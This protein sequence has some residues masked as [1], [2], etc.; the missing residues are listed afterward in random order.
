[1]P[2]ETD[3]AAIKTA[4]VTPAG[5]RM[6]PGVEPAAVTAFV[7]ALTSA[8]ER[9]AGISGRLEAARVH[10]EAFGKLIDA[11]KVRDAYHNR[12]PATEHNLGEAR[13]VLE[14]LIAGF[15]AAAASAAGPAAS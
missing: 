9:L 12:L 13:A 7:G 5:I 11:A 6:L 3:N 4:A 8:S 10:D 15:T 14:H 2:E 1:M